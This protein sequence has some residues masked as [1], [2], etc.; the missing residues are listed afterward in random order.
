MVSWIFFDLGCTLVDETRSDELYLQELNARLKTHG[1][2]LGNVRF[3]RAVRDIIGRRVVTNRREL[4]EFL[5]TEYVGGSSKRGL[6]TQLFSKWPGD[7]YTKLWVLHSDVMPTLSLISTGYNCGIIANQTS[8]GRSF[9]ESQKKF[10][11]FF[12][13]IVLSAEVGI[14]KPDPGIFHLAL[15]RAKA[16]ARDSMYVGD[17]VDFDVA[18]AKKIGMITVRV[19]RPGMF[20]QLDPVREMETPDY[21]IDNLTLLLNVLKG[22]D[23]HSSV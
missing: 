18:P 2:R 19:R 1:V 6:L 4:A 5:I 23:H 20:S 8:Y 17:R 13:A 9:V 21:V 3:R 14:S 12:K 16:K 22:S 11:S 7:R 10:R 15:H